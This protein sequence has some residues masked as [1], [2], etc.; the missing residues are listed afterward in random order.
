MICGI[1][2]NVSA[3]IPGVLVVGGQWRSGVSRP[4]TSPEFNNRLAPSSAVKRDNSQLLRLFTSSRPLIHITEGK[5]AIFGIFIVSRTFN[6]ILRHLVNRDVDSQ[7]VLNFRLIF[8][9]FLEPIL[10]SDANFFT[11]FCLYLLI[12]ITCL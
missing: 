3:A 6:D 7:F 10:A 5:S 4:I 9:T 2:M 1:I 12:V 8:S 11:S